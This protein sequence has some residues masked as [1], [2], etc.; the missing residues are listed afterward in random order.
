MNGGDNILHFFCII[1][2]PLMINNTTMLEESTIRV[3]KMHFDAAGRADLV[4]FSDE[5]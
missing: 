3:K 5:E 4:L 1:F 2:F